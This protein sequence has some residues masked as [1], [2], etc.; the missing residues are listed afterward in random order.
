MGC[1][2]SSSTVAGYVKSALEPKINAVKSELRADFKA[3]S[4]KQQQQLDRIEGQL[5]ELLAIL[6]PESIDKPKLVTKREAG[7]GR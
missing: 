3:T 4:E 6:K 5:A 7:A 1:Y 2:T